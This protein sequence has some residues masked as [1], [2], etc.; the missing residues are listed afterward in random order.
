MKIL[1][2]SATQLEIQPFLLTLE[3]IQV[4]PDVLIAGL[5]TT[6]TAYHLTKQLHHHHYDLVIQAGV[7]GSFD[8]RVARGGVV[9][10]KHDCFADLG[11]IEQNQFQTIQ[12]MGFSNEPEWFV[13]NNHLL[14]KLPYKQI[15]AITVS[16]VTDDA[17]TI[18]RQQQR[19]DADIETMEGA[20]LHYVCQHQQTSYLQLRS[21]SN[22]VGIRDK[23]QWDIKAAIENLNAALGAIIKTL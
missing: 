12:Q 19:W 9:I 1:L 6:A 5:G 22:A 10:V 3:S 11:A 7:A 20:A 4:K 17:A 13:N 14:N 8:D 18:T 23:A 21:I 15:K 2:V 16:T